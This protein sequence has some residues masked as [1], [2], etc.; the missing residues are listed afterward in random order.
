MLKRYLL[1]LL[2]ILFS[3]NAFADGQ[4]AAKPEEKEQTVAKPAENEQDVIKLDEVV[5]TATR[6]EQPMET[7]PGTVNIVTKKEM[8]TKNITTID[9]ALDTL[10]GVYNKRQS[11]TDIEASITLNGIPDQK[12][13]LIM[14][15]G[16]PLN[17]AFDG[18]VNFSALP[19]ENVERVEVVQGP[20]SSL[21]GGNAMGGA[22]NIITQMPEKREFTLISGYGSSWN[23]GEAIDDFQK[24]Y[25]SYGDRLINKLSL[26][27]SYGYKSTDGYPSNFNVQ[28]AQP[29]AGITGYSATTDNGQ[30]G[31]LPAY[32]IGDTGDNAWWDDNFTIKTRFDFT[33]DSKLSVSF[34]RMRYKYSYDDPHTYLKDASGNPVYEYGP[35][36]PGYSNYTVNQ[37]TFDYGSGGKEVNMYNIGYETEIGIV[38]TKFTL[39]LSDEGK[40]WYVSPGYLDSTTLAGG[41]G[42]V[43]STPSQNYTADLLFSVPVFSMNILTFGGSF[44][45]DWANSQVNNLTDWQDETSTTDL[46]S[47]QGGKDRTYAA[48]IQ[49]EILILSN[50]TAYIGFREDWWETY[51]GYANQFGSGGFANTYDSRNAASFSPKLSVVYK[52]FEIATLKADVGQAFR[53]PTVYELY[54]KWSYSGMIWSGNPD[55]KPET[56]TSWDASVVQELWKGAKVSATYF[57]N[58]IQD[59]I[60]SV[61]VPSGFENMNAGKAESQGIMLSFEQRFDK[62]LRLFA[63]YTY[64][65]GRIKENSA[66]PLSVGKRM[67]FLPDTMINAG[68]ECEI[69]QFSASV[70]VRYVSKIYS[71]DQNRD[72]IN[73]VYMSYDPYFTADAKVSYKVTNFATVSASVDNIFNE[74]YF[75]YYKAPGRSWFMEVALNF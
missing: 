9:E 28:S 35:P 3:S 40:N 10:P 50:L 51:D 33:P 25:I 43:T 22:V 41:P 36:I 5:V 42:Q 56:T 17:N 73:G 63:N 32:T 57:D 1:V 68:A 29:P 24:Y 61:S 47:N 44:K 62:L 66:D 67:T 75:S 39:G 2:L 71:D 55:L 16:I 52:P 23:R 53:A 49:D 31:G 18:T 20:F 45:T 14:M 48:F 38:K 7:A 60:Y 65:D 30:Y 26:L 8:E 11:L 74:S 54:S 64:T 6:I 37:S 34:M 58:H 21:Y 12:R 27:L 72:T 4:T 13:T 59:L 15:D 19:T 70:T 69:G 46:V